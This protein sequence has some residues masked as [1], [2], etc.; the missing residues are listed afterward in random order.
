MSICEINTSFSL[1]YSCQTPEPDK[2][3]FKIAVSQCGTNEDCACD[4]DVDAK[5]SGRFLFHA[6]CPGQRLFRF[7]VTL[8]N[9]SC[10]YTRSR[11]IEAADV[12][13]SLA[14]VSRG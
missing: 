5:L 2:S 11:R 3:N 12:K 8:A 6:F 7:S 9:Y 10:V 1:S 14:E 13:A 4:A